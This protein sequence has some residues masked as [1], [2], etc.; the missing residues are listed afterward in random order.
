ML[1]SQLR[2]IT[3]TII[4]TDVIYHMVTFLQLSDDHAGIGSTTRN[5][6]S[7]YMTESFTGVSHRK[8]LVHVY[9]TSGMTFITL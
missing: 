6:G 7:H 3:S 1:G 9:N 2:H 4:L 8:T 5:K